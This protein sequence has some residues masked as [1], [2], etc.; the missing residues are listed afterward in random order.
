MY[1][2]QF[3]NEIATALPSAARVIHARR[4]EERGEILPHMEMSDLIDWAGETYAA[5]QGPNEA[6]RRARW[7]IE[8]FLRMLED[9]FEVGDQDLDDLIATSFLEGLATTRESLPG[10]RGLLGPWML[11]WYRKACEGIE[12]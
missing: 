10:L 7:E 12:D 5:S 6:G 4:Q 11:A 9:G 2:V 1:T 8:L 3:M